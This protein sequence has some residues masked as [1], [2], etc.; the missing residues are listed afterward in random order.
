[1]YAGTILKRKGYDILIHAFAKI[2]KDV[3]EWKIVFAGNPYY[4]NGINEI[5]HGKSIAENYGI[6]S[7][8]EWLGWISGER[9]E[10]VFNESSIYCLA[11]DGEGFPMGILDA[12]AYGIPC[13]MT[14]VGGIPDIVRDG[15]EGLLFPV[16]NVEMLSIQL[17]SMIIDKELR[18]NIVKATDVY[19]NNTFEIH[20]INRQLR[21]IYN[22]II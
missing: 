16:G 8:V 20:E 13:I 21:D 22:K 17:K 9:K 10:E 15:I 3:P 11:S 18:S 2:A 19:V 12:W 4:E 5:E 14:P 6:S 7:Q 1:M